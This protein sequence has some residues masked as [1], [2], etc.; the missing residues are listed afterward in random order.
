MTRKSYTADFET[1]TDKEDC[2]VW[3]WCIV[4]IDNFDERYFGNNIQT[5][6]LQVQELGKCDIYFHNL[7]FDSQFI[8]YWLLKNDFEY[9]CEKQLNG[10]EFNTL[11]NSS[12]QIYSL[13][14]C[15]KVGTSKTGKE[16][17][18]NVT[19]KDSLKK[20]P[21]TVDKI[22]KDFKLPI[23]KL[24]IDYHAKREIGHELTKE[25]Q[26]YILNDTL[27]MA[28]ALNIQFK[29]GLTKLTIGSDALTSYKQTMPQFK[30]LF[31]VLEMSEDNFLRKAYHGGWCY[32]NP[33]YQMKDIG[34]GQVFDVNSLYPWALRFNEYP[35]GKPQFYV[36][37]YEQDNE[38]PLYVQRFRCCFKLRKGKFPIV[39]FKNLRF[40][41][42]T[43][44]QV[45]CLEQQEMTMCNVDLKLFLEN[46]E[47]WDMEY[48][49]GYKFKKQADL[50][51]SYIDQWSS[52]KETSTG[53]I[54]SLAKLMLNNLYGKFATNPHIIEKKPV[55]KDGAVEYEVA[56][57]YDNDGVYIP[58]GLFCTAY[59]REKTV[60]T[61]QLMYDRFIYADTDSL[62]IVGQDIPKEIETQVHDTKLGYWKRESIF[63]RARFLKA[64]TYI[65]EENKEINVKCA[66][67][68]QAIKDKVTW[69]NFRTGFT[70]YGKL[71][72]V[73]VKGGVVL[74]DREFTIKSTKLN[75]AIA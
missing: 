38:Y 12:N 69:E 48:M 47:V 50:F 11:I 21:F 71:V 23:R 53:A 34:K 9:S 60:R 2:R 37:E 26:D 52:I 17:R 4:S 10:L 32:V 57:E 45:E 6:I 65:E 59:A 66:G 13:E 20:L 19:F 33:K 24:S 62:H 27:I 64:K 25:E 72:P 5:F 61:A 70:S 35:I 51:N 41:L 36:G 30:E 29:Q 55:I 28:M 73:N 8:I 67:M 1:T 58:V 43:E 74:E 3:A 63:D 75:K 18:R 16:Y 42:D 15:F 31:P 14:V 49:C 7:K 40:F 46:Y 39:Q 22:A 54:R 56:D 44:Y 68:P